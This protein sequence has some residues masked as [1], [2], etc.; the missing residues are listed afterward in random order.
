MTGQALYAVYNKHCGHVLNI[1]ADRAVQ[2]PIV[3]AMQ[4]VNNWA[5]RTRRATDADITALMQGVRCS[6]CTLDGRE[7]EPQPTTV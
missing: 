6:K 2:E 7:I 5:L 4:P 3:E 1:H